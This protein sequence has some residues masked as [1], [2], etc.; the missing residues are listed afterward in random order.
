MKKKTSQKTKDYVLYNTFVQIN[1]K[2]PIKL[3]FK[4]VKNY[5]KCDFF[6]RPV[7]KLKVETIRNVKSHQK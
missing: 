7:L 4:K 5:N 3:L 6:R 2:F 1:K